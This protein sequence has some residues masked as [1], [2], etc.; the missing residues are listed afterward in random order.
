MNRIADIN[1]SARSRI[2][3]LDLLIARS[4]IADIEGSVDSLFCY[5]L[6]LNVIFLLF[7]VVLA[8]SRNLGE[9]LPSVRSL[10]LVLPKLSTLGLGKE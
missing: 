6:V 10:A 7:V 4:L 8:G 1:I 5:D 3:S 2:R 9:S